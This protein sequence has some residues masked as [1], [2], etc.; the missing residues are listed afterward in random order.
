MKSARELFKQLGYDKRYKRG[1][2]LIYEKT[3]NKVCMVFDLEEY[4]ID[5]GNPLGSLSINYEELQ[6][7]SQQINELGWK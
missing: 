6:A 3:V 1:C 4:T 7:I 5:K 2:F